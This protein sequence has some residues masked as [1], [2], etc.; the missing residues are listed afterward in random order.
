MATLEEIIE[1]ELARLA[2]RRESPEAFEALFW[3]LYQWR[4]ARTMPAR[5][6]R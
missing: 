2:R 4:Q 6:D 5:N 3:C 1:S